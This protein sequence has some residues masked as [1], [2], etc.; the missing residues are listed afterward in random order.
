MKLTQKD[1]NF[2]H[3]F[4]IFTFNIN[5]NNIINCK[6]KKVKL[7]FYS[8]LGYLSADMLMYPLDTLATYIK[9]YKKSHLS[10]YQGYKKIFAL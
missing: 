8:S 7:A 10:I 1:I 4:H 9:S 2:N 6:K 5:K 3:V